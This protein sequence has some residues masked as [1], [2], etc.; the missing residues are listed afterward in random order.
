VTMES[1]QTVVMGG[2]M[3]EE[4]STSRQGVPGLMDI[5]LLGQAASQNIKQNKVT[6]LVVFI[7][8]TLANAPSTVMD[9]DIRLYRKFTPDPRP[10]A[11]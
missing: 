5:P 9:E 7:R 2:M 6:E 4:V 1:G 10:I 3:Q 11:F 8:A